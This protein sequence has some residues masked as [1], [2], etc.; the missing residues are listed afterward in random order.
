MSVMPK[1]IATDLLIDAAE[2]RKSA[3]GTVVLKPNLRF[4]ANFRTPSDQG[5]RSGCD[6][7]TV[8]HEENDECLDIIR[9][10]RW[11]HSNVDE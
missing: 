6:F 8:Y 1:F 11:I 9:G 5:W 7:P 2:H 10:Y 4:Y 3:D